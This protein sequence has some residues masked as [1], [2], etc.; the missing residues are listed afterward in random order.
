MD[1][2]LV[3]IVDVKDPE[4]YMEYVRAA[5]A[6]AAKYGGTFL[7]RGVPDET[8][9]GNE[10][11]K[12]IVVSKWNSPEAARAYYQSAEYAAAKAKRP[13]DVADVNWP[14]ALNTA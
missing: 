6:A 1:D 2:Y 10:T 14:A 4:R 3:S 7:L 5:N 9:E 11:G 8:L 13:R 12:R